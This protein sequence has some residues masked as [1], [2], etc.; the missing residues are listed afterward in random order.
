MIFQINANLEIDLDLKDHP[1]H[2]K[3]FLLTSDDS[4]PLSS[5]SNS[6]FNT[7]GGGRQAVIQVLDPMLL[8]LGSFRSHM[9]VRRMGMAGAPDANRN[10]LQA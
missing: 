1:R 9:Q 2:V 7:D 3:S 5:S 6:S 4:C 10:L 8:L